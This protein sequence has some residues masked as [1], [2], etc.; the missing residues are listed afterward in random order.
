MGKTVYVSLF[1]G[2]STFVCLVVLTK[3]RHGVPKGLIEKKKKIYIYNRNK[4]QVKLV[5]K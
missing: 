2:I 3:E 1:N 4:I 5:K